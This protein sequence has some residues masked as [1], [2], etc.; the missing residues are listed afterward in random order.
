MRESLVQLYS[1]EQLKAPS[2]RNQ[3]FN[4]NVVVST[5]T[6]AVKVAFDPTQNISTFVQNIG[7]AVTVASGNAAFGFAGMETLAAIK[8]LAELYMVIEKFGPDA[9]YQLVV[10]TPVFDK[11]YSTVQLITSSQSTG[12]LPQLIKFDS[13]N[14]DPMSF[15]GFKYGSLTVMSDP[16]FPVQIITGANGSGHT[17]TTYYKLPGGQ[18]D[19]RLSVAAGS[20]VKVAV[21]FLLGKGAFYDFES[22]PL[23]FRENDQDYGRNVGVGAFRV[24]GFS[25]G[26]FSADPATFG[27]G[28]IDASGNWTPSIF[29]KASALVLFPFA[30]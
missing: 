22:S 23:Q 1:S 12:Y 2:N 29:N 30:P 6:G 19:Y 10:P 8:Q 25:A 17:I 5:A 24:R 27:G 4:P 15:E 3:G 7:D 14:G 26:V 16:R 21:G 18:A 20:N 28:L 11:L 9:G 13:K